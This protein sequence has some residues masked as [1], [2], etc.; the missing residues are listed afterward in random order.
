VVPEF[1][2]VVLEGY[3]DV[4]KGPVEMGKVV[5]EPELQLVVKIMRPAAVP[6]KA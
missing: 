4:G 6:P 2:P 5:V 1:E 3:P